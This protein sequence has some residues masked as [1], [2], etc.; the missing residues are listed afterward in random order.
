MRSEEEV[1][2]NKFESNYN[3]P[4]SKMAAVYSGRLILLPTK[5]SHTIATYT[6][7]ISELFTNSTKSLFDT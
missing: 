7:Y 1:N 2:L 6:D 5:P 4:N 3:G